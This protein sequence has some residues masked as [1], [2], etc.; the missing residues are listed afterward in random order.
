MASLRGFLERKLA[1][2][3]GEEA[4]GSCDG[5]EVIVS[6]ALVHSFL[7]AGTL[8]NTMCM[9]AYGKALSGSFKSRLDC[10]SIRRPPTQNRGTSST[11]SPVAVT[12]PIGSVTILRLIT[13]FPPSA[14]ARATSAS[15]AFKRWT[16]ITGIPIMPGAIASAGPTNWRTL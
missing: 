10:T 3:F 12:V 8:D 15:T 6:S 2:S 9:L 11:A 5:Q 13:P 14:P 1:L 4:S 16:A 7:L